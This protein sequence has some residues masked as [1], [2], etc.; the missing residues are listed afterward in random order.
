[1]MPPVLLFSS[2]DWDGKWGSRQQVALELAKLG[3]DVLFV[4][5]FAGLEHWVRYSGLRERRRKNKVGRLRQVEGL[6][7]WKV[8][9]PL[10]LPG[11]YYSTGIA[12][13]NA[14][15]A[16]GQLSHAI[17]KFL[18][19]RRPILWLFKPEHHFL[20]GQLD[21]LVSVYHCIDEFTVGT[22]GRKKQ[23][24]QGLERALLQKV[25]VA[26]ANS[27]LTYENKKSVQPNCF[28]VPSGA[29]I[30]HFGNTQSADRHLKL[31]DLQRPILIFAGQI[32]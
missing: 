11:A 9:P 10:L 25:D 15:R 7:L 2:S 1:M 3:H 4:E 21:E 29:N 6:T 30:G 32:N 17:Q 12:Q 27:I 5:R 23:V 16:L 20:V 24:I 13:Q 26:F 31:R 14:K 18:A 8:A 19:G 28:R 22:T